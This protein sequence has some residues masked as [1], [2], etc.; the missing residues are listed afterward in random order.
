MQFDGRHPKKPRNVH[1]VA[2]LQ[3]NVAAIRSYFPRPRGSGFL[4]WQIFGVDF[5]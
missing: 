5:M 2:T 4:A 1:V 3:S